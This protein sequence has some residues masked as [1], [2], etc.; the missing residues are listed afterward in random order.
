MANVGT[1]AAPLVRLVHIGEALIGAARVRVN[2]A[3]QKRAAR[4]GA[5][6]IGAAQVGAARVRELAVAGERMTEDMVMATAGR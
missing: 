3:A 6:Q 1:S 2:A 4:D 5:A